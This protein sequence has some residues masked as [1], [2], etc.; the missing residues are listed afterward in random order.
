MVSVTEPH[1]AEK[2]NSPSNPPSL[3]P[4]KQPSPPPSCSDL[5]GFNHLFQNK[6]SGFPV[7]QRSS[8]G[9]SDHD[10]A[11]PDLSVVWGLWCVTS[12]GRLDIKLSFCPARKSWSLENPLKPCSLILCL[13]LEDQLVCVCVCA[14]CSRQCVALFGNR[15]VLKLTAQSEVWDVCSCVWVYVSQ[16]DQQQRHHHTHTHT[17]I[18]CVCGGCKHTHTLVFVWDNACVCSHP[19]DTIKSCV[20]EVFLLPF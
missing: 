18:V 19:A 8:P 9:E 20:F 1:A 12:L 11:N 2:S 14:P 10:W 15:S 13:F 4:R 7:L 5:G 16:K 17:A 3:R 6:T